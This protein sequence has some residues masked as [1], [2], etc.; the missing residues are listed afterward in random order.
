MGD[1]RARLASVEVVQPPLVS[2]RNSSKCSNVFSV[3]L[4]GRSQVSNGRVLTVECFVVIPLTSRHF[5]L[6]SR[7]LLKEPFN[8]V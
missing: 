5:V 3:D 1:C 8:T 4:D 6:T 2:F 7:S